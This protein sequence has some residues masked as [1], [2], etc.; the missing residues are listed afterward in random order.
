MSRTPCVTV[1]IPTRNRASF[2]DTSIR[3][4]LGQTR[5]DLE[6]IVVDDA[7]EDHTSEVVSEFSDPRLRY[8]RQEEPRGAPAARNVAIRSSTS[9]YVAFL[10]DDDEWMPEKLEL[11]IELFR[12]GSGPETAVVY[13]SYQVV[14]RQSGRVVGRKVAEKRGDLARDLLDRNH[15]GATSCVVVR[16]SALERSGFWDERMPSFQDYD[17]WIR[18]SREWRFDFVEQ[19]LLKYYVH[20][21]KIWTDLGALDRGIELM[22]QKHGE[23][24]ALRRN[25]SGHSLGVGEGY[26]T[27]GEMEKGRRSI[28]RAIRLRPTAAR[29][30][31]NYALSLLGPAAFRQVHR[32]KQR[33]TALAA[34]D[35]T[36]APSK[37]VPE[38]AGR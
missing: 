15:I 33:L 16:R 29:A 12:N 14:D 10:D 8:L 30:Y 13:S 18:L 31:L 22:V 27:R 21:D 34:S 24:R 23:S 28:R 4:A 19:D 6:V 2:L 1:V 17:L 11:Q 7:S 26:C 5:R 35:R 36:V 25:L 37:H 32:A 3:S 38:E 9:E 20:A